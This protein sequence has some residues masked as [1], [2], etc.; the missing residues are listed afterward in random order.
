MGHGEAATGFQWHLWAEGQR[1]GLL[2]NQV[3]VL[4]S[5]N[6]AIPWGLGGNHKENWAT[7]D[8]SAVLRWGKKLICL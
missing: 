4:H 1:R 3:Q 2:L 6:H 8:F 5:R 7:T